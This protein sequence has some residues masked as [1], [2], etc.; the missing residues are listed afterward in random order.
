LQA[1][2]AAR[3]YFFGGVPGWLVPGLLPGVGV[4]GFL[5]GWPGLSLC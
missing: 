2:R 1:E 3:F 4:L 5:G